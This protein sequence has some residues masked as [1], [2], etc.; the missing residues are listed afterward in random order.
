VY[1]IRDTTFFHNVVL[2]NNPT[3]GA[4]IDSNQGHIDSVETGIVRTLHEPFGAGI[5]STGSASLFGDDPIIIENQFLFIA[6]ESG[7]LGLLLFGILIGLIFV[8]LWQRRSDWRALAVLASG[9]GMLVI[10]VFLPV[11]VDDTVSIVWWGFAAVLLAGER[12][13]KHARTTNKKA[14]RTT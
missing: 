7:W 3:T 4:E 6:H 13:I 10:G 12:S 11:W 2:H 8:K 1:A 5:G 14:K 9:I